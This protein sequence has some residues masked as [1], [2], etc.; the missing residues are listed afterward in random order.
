[1]KYQNLEIKR[2]NHAAFKIKSEKLVIYFNPFEID[3]DELA[4]LVFI[5]HERF[6]HCPPNDLNKIINEGT[7]IVASLI[8]QGELK[9]LKVKEIKYLKPFE[10]FEIEKVKVRTIPAY[11]LNKFREPGK[12]FHPKEKPRLGYV[13]EIKGVRIY[14]AGDTDNIPEMRVLKDV[15]IALLPVSGTYVMTVEEAVEAVKVIN[16]KLA[17]PMHYGAIVGTIKDAERF[18]ELSPVQ[19]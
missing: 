2:L 17:I 12:V 9:N 5:T 14:H 18:K 10:N 13:L 4:N 3:S 19:T 11:N 1:M 15:D 7:I 6:D 16:P 8:C